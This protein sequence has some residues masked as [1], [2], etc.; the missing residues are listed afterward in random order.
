MMKELKNE[1]EKD[2]KSELAR[3]N[4]VH[5]LFGSRHEGLAVIAEEVFEV[6]KEMDKLARTFNIFRYNVFNDEYESLIGDVAAMKETAT[7]LACEAIQVAAMC[8]KWNL[9][10]RDSTVEE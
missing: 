2:I 1:V 9:G 7:N 5:P 4:V 10:S 8:E 3:A 6:A